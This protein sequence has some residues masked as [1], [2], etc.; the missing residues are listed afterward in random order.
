MVSEYNPQ[1]LHTHNSAQLVTDQRIEVLWAGPLLF[2]ISEI[3]MLKE[4]VFTDDEKN[5]F[6]I[7]KIVRHS[8]VKD[9]DVLHYTEGVAETGAEFEQ[10]WKK[11]LA[12]PLKVRQ[13][14]FRQ[15]IQLKPRAV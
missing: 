6:V 12:F 5:S 8:I 14:N 15:D 7:D 3:A 4:S 10:F 2:K 13:Y 9:E 1:Q 11:I